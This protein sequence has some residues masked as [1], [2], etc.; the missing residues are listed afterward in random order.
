MA[1]TFNPGTLRYAVAFALSTG[2]DLSFEELV[3]AAHASNEKA[4]KGNV[5]SALNGLSAAGLAEYDHD[6]STWCLTLAGLARWDEQH[7]AESEKPAPGSHLL[8]PLTDVSLLV[9]NTKRAA[10]VPNPVNTMPFTPRDG[11]MDF[12]AH[13]RIS[14]PWRI[15]PC[16]KRERIDQPHNNNHQVKA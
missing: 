10:V 13:P 9:R 4:T 3:A 5:K 8:P 7:L 14:G 16:G 15:W 6:T 11:A 1:R 2:K 12:A